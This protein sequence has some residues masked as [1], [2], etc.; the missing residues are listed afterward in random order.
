[1]VR[2]VMV[3]VVT[4]RVVTVPGVMVRVV[5]ARCGRGERTPLPAAAQSSAQVAGR[6]AAKASRPSRPSAWRRFSTIASVATR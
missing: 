1:M 5:P 6:L 2:V 4:V 3:R